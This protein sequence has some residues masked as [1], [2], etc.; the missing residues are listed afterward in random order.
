[1]LMALFALGIMIALKKFL[2]KIPNVLTA[3]VITTLLS[4]QIGFE[5]MGGRVVG[6]IPAGLPPLS[7]PVL[8][9]YGGN[10][11]PAVKRSA[12]ERLQM[13][14]QAGHPKS[15]QQVIPGADHYFTDAGQPLL[16]AVA[17]WLDDL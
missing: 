16:E 11:F 10:E 14:Q 2:P 9:I 12:P 3:V 8:D 5:Q 4:W 6:S 1:M 13:L 15:R 17:A 7:M